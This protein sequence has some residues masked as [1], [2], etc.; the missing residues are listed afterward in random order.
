MYTQLCHTNSGSGGC[1]GQDARRSA[2][3]AHLSTKS[4]ASE[5]SADSGCTNRLTSRTACGASEG[6][7]SCMY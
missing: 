2:L 1:S 7:A 6:M 5:E 3:N 4:G